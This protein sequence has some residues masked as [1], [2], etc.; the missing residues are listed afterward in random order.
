M[1]DRDFLKRFEKQ[2]IQEGKLIEAG[3]IG[4]RLAAIP[5]TASKDQLEDMRV[6]FFAGAHHLFNSIMHVL[7]DDREPT[8]ADMARMSRIHEELEVFIEGFKKKHGFSLGTEH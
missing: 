6:A 4:L 3:F 7:D 2:L 8:E 5:A 1:A